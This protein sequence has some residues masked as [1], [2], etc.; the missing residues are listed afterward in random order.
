MY[1]IAEL[2][3]FTD[4]SLNNWY[5]NAKANYNIDGKGKCFYDEEENEIVIYYVENGEKK[6]WSMAFY[7]EY[8]KEQKIKWVYDC[9][10]ELC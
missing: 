7:D 9:W 8:R 3:K 10:M 6:V 1:T 2:I 4:E 5:L